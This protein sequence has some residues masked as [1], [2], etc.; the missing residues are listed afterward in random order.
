MSL[1]TPDSFS[2]PI[3]L[4]SVTMFVLTFNPTLVTA[5]DTVNV[6]PFVSTL[7]DAVFTPDEDVEFCG[8]SFS[9]TTV[10][11]AVSSISFGATT[12]KLKIIGNP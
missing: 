7:V 9:G 8:T 5:N 12:G 11:L 4:G 6:S 1:K 10:T 2:D 3:S